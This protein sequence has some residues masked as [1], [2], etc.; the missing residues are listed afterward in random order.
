MA[1]ISLKTLLFA[2]VKHAKIDLEK[3]FAKSKVNLTPFQY[4][5]MSMLKHQPSTLNDL[6][7]KLG[8]KP[9]SLTDPIDALVKKGYVNRTEDRVDRRKIHL[10]VTKKGQAIIK[11]IF[12]DQPSDSLNIAFHKLSKTYGKYYRS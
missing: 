9:P 12:Q 6:A 4:G 5:I 3:K 11:K 7:Q 8:V 2:L 1:Q 10:T